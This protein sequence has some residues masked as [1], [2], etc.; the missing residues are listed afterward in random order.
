VIARHR[1]CLS[2]WKR[3]AGPTGRQ[4]VGARAPYGDAVGVG[5]DPG[6]SEQLWQV[7]AMGK[8]QAG[9]CAVHFSTDLHHANQCI[10]A[11]LGEDS[12]VYVSAYRCK[13]SDSAR[14]GS[15]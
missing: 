4:D 1:A 12:P 2:K 6:G 13:H 3:A 5:A 15:C 9:T 8:R 14:S 10:A 7:F 11:A